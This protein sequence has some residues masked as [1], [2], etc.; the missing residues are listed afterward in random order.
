[1]YN[2]DLILTELTD[3]TDEDMDRFHHLPCTISRSN[4]VVKL[5]FTCK[6]L[7]RE[8][9]ISEALLF[10]AAAGYKCS[11]AESTD[12]LVTEKNAILLRLSSEVDRVN[13]CAWAL[14]R[15]DTMFNVWCEHSYAYKGAE[16]IQNNILPILHLQIV[17]RENLRVKVLS[18]KARLLMQKYYMEQQKR[19]ERA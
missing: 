10:V 11:L 9:A 14:E 16:I 4:R 13:D 6:G 1:M 18:D 3:F 8:H 5:S 2:F 7:T 12:P 15:L 19:M 17:G